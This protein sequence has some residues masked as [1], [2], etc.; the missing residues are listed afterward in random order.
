AAA[1][2][3][4]AEHLVRAGA[5]QLLHLFAVARFHGTAE[6]RDE[7]PALV[8]P[9]APA[10]A[11]VAPAFA[12]AFALRLYEAGGAA[13]GERAGPRAAAARREAHAAD[14]GAVEAALAAVDYLP[15]ADLVETSLP[16]PRRFR[17]YQAGVGPGQSA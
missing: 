1:P 6:W 15:F 10:L 8:A 14:S 16:T 13:A 2:L 4:A 12:A 3:E 9:L 5:V 17:K 7:L 11:A